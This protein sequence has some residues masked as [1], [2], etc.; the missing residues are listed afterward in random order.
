MHLIILAILISNT[1]AVEV[2]FTEV[3]PKIDGFI[4]DVW[5]TADSAY[6][7]VQ[8]DP[9]EKEVPTERTVVYVLQDKDN[10]YFAFRGY[11][12]KHKPIACLTADED[13]VAIGL[14]PFGNKTTGY[15]FMVFA[16]GIPYDGWIHD[17]GRTRDD[18]WEGV[19]F[20]GVQVYDDRLDIEIKIPFKS[21]R[22]KKGLNEWGLQIM[23][24]SAANHETDFWNEV[25][26]K[27]GD[28]VSKWPSLTGINPQATG[29]YFELYPEGFVRFD[30][31]PSDTA[32]TKYKPSA[33][34]NFKWDVSSQITLNAT[35]YPDF[36]QIESDPFELN[37]SR[38]PTYL[39][40]R[41]P[42]F[43]EGSDIFRMSDFGEHRGFFHSLNIFYSRK[44]GRSMNGDAVPIIGGLK[45]TT[46]SKN[47]NLGAFGAY[48]D[49]Y[50]QN[51]TII[52]SRKGFGVIR[53]KQSILKNSDIGMLLSASAVDRDTYNYAIGLDGVYRK[54]PNQFIVQGAMSDKNR[55]RGLALNAGFFGFLG[56]FLTIGA[57]EVVD[58]SFDVTDIGFVPWA[59][60][61][62]FFLGS[63]PFKQYQK[64][65]LST[66]FWGPAGIIVQEPGNTEW[67][68]LA[69][70]EINP[71]F[72]NNWGC[73]LSGFIGPY[74]EA[75]TN[76]LY[77]SANLSTW[78]RLFG[79]N[80]NFGGNY[81]YTYN[82]RRSFLSY[83]GSNWF[84]YN[85]SIIPQLSVGINTNFWLEWDTTNTIIEITEVI[86]PS[87]FLRVNA[88]MNVRIFN[89]FVTATPQKNFSETNLISNR[90][91]LLFSWNF[92]PK[93]WLYV[94]LNDYQERDFQ[95]E[96]LQPVYRIA[97]VKAKYL[98]Y[99]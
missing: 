95:L 69:G 6:D 73:D 31:Y 98:I 50:L 23:R 49:K 24:Y 27:E 56:D 44:V 89:E 57:A 25:S 61:K 48:T 66:I 4:E 77:R 59:G 46:K 3:A 55:K 26:K 63:G 54:G 93:S 15:Y 12:E 5:Q 85:H 76:Y 37:L 68:K 60:I 62:R 72:R 81:S 99:F 38:Y 41:R 92:K 22:Y 64:G 20:R 11:A 34:L 86:R 53:A 70:F 30:R 8:H 17:D 47:F 71:G 10:L 87:I 90:L 14:D 7:F 88:D 33:S 51:D 42:F 84:S 58:D 97:A 79:N 35:A 83:Q 2:K 21:I 91:G 75:D 28:L 43:L 78:G 1:K 52:E 67:S 94:A 13:F 16:S 74:Y 80:I 19:W 96:K 45:L 18:S 36:A 39:T 82:Y 32:K 65:F 29:Y 40:E 9:Y